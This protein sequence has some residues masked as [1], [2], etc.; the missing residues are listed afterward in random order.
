MSSLNEKFS[1]LKQDAL[2]GKVVRNSAH[3]FSSNSFSL[4]LSFLMGVMSAQL[5]GV[6]GF[7]LVGL[8]MGYA[9]TVNSLLSFR[10]G[11]LVVRYGGEYLQRGEKDKASTVFKI[12]AVAETIVS[13]LAFVFVALTAG[14]ASQYL[15]KTPGT[16]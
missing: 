8:V 16:G 12:A 10:M 3:L 4:A 9:S 14:S 11:E 7:G 1:A 2:L 13:V 5:L 15:T 6:A